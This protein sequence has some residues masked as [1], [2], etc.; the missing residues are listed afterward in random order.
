MTYPPKPL[1]EDEKKKLRE[2][3]LLRALSIFGRV[4]HIGSMLYA[5]RSIAHEISA[6][7]PAF[8]GLEKAIEEVWLKVPDQ[9][10]KL[11]E[12]LGIVPED[13]EYM[14]PDEYDHLRARLNGIDWEV[15][16]DEPPPREHPADILK[17]LGGLR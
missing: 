16:D 4:A 9:H 8:E 2:V 14:R 10:Q 1:D 11:A 15:Y 17:K 13:Y 3:A 12:A 5:A 6:E 7:D